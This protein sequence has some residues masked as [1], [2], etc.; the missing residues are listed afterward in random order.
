MERFEAPQPGGAPLRG[1]VP[2]VGASGRDVQVTRH[3]SATGGTFPAF[4]YKFGCLERA[5]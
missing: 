4:C 3:F 2:G 5:S 1:E